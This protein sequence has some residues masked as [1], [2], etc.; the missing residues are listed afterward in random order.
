MIKIF[1][2]EFI[3]RRLK[4][5]ETRSTFAN[6]CRY[7]FPRVGSFGSDVPTL[8]NLCKHSF[9][10]HSWCFDRA[11]GNVL[12]LFA[13]DPLHSVSPIF[14]KHSWHRNHGLGKKKE[15]KMLRDRRKLIRIPINLSSLY[16]LTFRSKNSFIPKKRIACIL[17][18]RSKRE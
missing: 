12:C 17:T 11:K 15:G 14:L 13:L 6:D 10:R 4:N 3:H 7:N 8:E 16:P 9:V 1:P 5:S 2:S 18:S